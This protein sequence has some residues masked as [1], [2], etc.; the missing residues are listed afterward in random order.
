MKKVIS[1]VIG[2]VLLG[3]LFFYSCSGEKQGP[4]GLEAEAQKAAEDFW[5]K[6]M[7]KCGDSHYSGFGFNPDAIF[8][9]KELSITVAPSTS[10]ISEAD[11]LNGIEWKGTTMLVAKAS[12]AFANPFGGGSWMDWKNGAKAFQETPHASIA[13][14]K[15]QWLIEALPWSFSAGMKVI[16]CSQIP[17]G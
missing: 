2:F 6:K 8:E 12:R 15:G 5:G 11:K 10:P 17:K 13:K 3:S 7:T 14:I 16:K 1:F 4:S 9:F